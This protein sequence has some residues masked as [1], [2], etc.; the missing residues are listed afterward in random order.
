MT[1]EQPVG[2]GGLSLLFD[3]VD[4]AS[5]VYFRIVFSLVVFFWVAK[6]L[7]SGAIDQ[8]YVE[9]RFHFH[10][11][12][13]HWVEL[14]PG[15]WTHV[16]FV[17]I[18]FAAL[19]MLLGA[20]YRIAAFVFAL[21]FT[22]LFVGDKCLYQNHYYLICLVS[23]I[24]VFIPANCVF[25]V[26][27]RFRPGLASQT[28]PRWV[29]WLLR[30][31]IGVPYFFGG[32]AKVNAD[33]LAGEPMR[34]MLARRVDMPFVGQYF[35]QEW[36]VYLMAYGALLFDLLVV[37]ALLTKRF[38]MIA[39]LFAILFH[40]LNSW[41]FTIGVFPWLMLLTLPI[42]F[43]AGTLRRLLPGHIE[44]EKPRKT[45]AS[46]AIVVLLLI[47]V[48]WQSVF[49]LRHCLISGN[50]SW[51]E[52]GHYFAW[53]ML[54]R[55][56]QSALRYTARDPL[57]GREGTIDLRPYVTAFQLNRVSR[58]P[59]LVH[60]L[61]RYIGDDLRGSGY[62]RVELSALCLVSMNGRKP[63]SL[64]D[65]TVDL[66]RVRQRWS[67]PDWIVPLKEPLRVPHWNKPLSDWVA[68]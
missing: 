31:Q 42:F 38:R 61:G 57:S 40:A 63:Q 56:K 55:G 43:P 21:G 4:C 59:R 9:P 30:F 17:V 23:W 3:R 27:A 24:M 36:C 49:P 22:H 64:V 8:F 26:D 60:E 6:Q 2:R 28:V 33:W 20:F 50:P 1:E 18:G 54:L 11:F 29:I 62:D 34:L 41:L 39:C 45:R 13:F 15:K 7:L 5:L 48:V 16:E 51:T 66:L 67:Q 46:P 52:E 53:H 68:P 14:F 32:I 25:S 12:G 35:A 44:V 19:L 58:D 65:P 37:P 47:F 10:Y